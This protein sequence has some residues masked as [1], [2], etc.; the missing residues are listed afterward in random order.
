MVDKCSRP[1]LLYHS[2]VRGRKKADERATVLAAAAA[3]SE[4]CAV[5]RKEKRSRERTAR[6]QH[7]HTLLSR[8]SFPC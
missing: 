3:A 6:T 4:Q 7:A 2:R 5:R 1:K 8:I